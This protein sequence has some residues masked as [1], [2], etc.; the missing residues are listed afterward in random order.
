MKLLE[1][2]ILWGSLLILGG[3][4]FLLQNLGILP[5]GDIFWAVL[6]GVAAAFF[7][8]VSFQNRKNWWALI[9]GMLLAGIA[10]LV[11]TVYIAPEITGIWGASIVL[12][13]LGLSFL[14]IYLVD[15]MNWWAIIPGGVLLTLAAMIGAGHYVPALETTGIFFLG[16]GGTFALVAILPNPQGEMRWAWIPAG[17]L[18]AIGVIMMAFTGELLLYI[19]PVVL[20]LAGVYLIFR[21]L[22]LKG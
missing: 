2:R 18:A 10:A 19:G 6:L 12:G 14:L 4:V 11:L 1:S 8:A 7:L 20:I 17:V 22:R 9:P 15:H 5:L 16:L 21:N 3:I 13:S